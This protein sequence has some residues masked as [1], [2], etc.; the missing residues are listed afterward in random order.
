MGHLT[1]C[2]I[3]IRIVAVLI[4]F[5]KLK[6]FKNYQNLWRIAIDDPALFRMV[7]A[8]SVR[9]R[10]IAGSCGIGSLNVG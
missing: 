1:G 9:H 3:R 4:A 6:P 10:H 5:R 7:Q 2:S 8:D